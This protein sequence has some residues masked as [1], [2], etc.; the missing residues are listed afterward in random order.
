MVRLE[1][2]MLRRERRRMVPERSKTM[3]RGP[4]A[5]MMP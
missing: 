3:V 2:L 4:V 1:R 5:E